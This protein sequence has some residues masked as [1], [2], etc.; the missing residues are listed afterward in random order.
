MLYDMN[1]NCYGTSSNLYTKVLF[2]FHLLTGKQT[3]E[4]YSKINIEHYYKSLNEVVSKANAK[5]GNANAYATADIQKQTDKSN[6]VSAIKSG[7]L[8]VATSCSEITEAILPKEEIIKVPFGGFITKEN[9]AAKSAPSG[10][11]FAAE[12]RIVD[13]DGRKNILTYNGDFY[14]NVNWS[15][16]LKTTNK[17][18]WFDNNISNNRTVYFLGR[19]VGDNTVSM[20]NGQDDFKVNARVVELICASTSK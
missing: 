12:G 3:N 14:K 13:F 15:Y 8:S 4:F 17:T 10:K 2:P 9:V 19:Y 16:A 1:N 11:I 5:L 7:N 20:T 6:R 18:I